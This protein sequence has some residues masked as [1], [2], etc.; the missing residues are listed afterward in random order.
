MSLLMGIDLGTSSV[1]SMIMD[2]SGNVLGFSQKEYDI[3]IPV[4]GYAEQNPAEWWDLVKETSAQAMEQAGTEG[5]TLAGIG[6]SGQMHGLV[7]LD[8]E[9]QVLRPAIIW[10]DQR[11]IPQKSVVES[12]F[13]KEQLGGMIQNPVST[14]FLL[15]SLMWI[16]ENEP[17]IYSK[18]ER[19]M[20]PKDYIRYRLTGELGTDTT[21]ASSTSAYD[22]AALQWSEPLIAAFGLERTMFPVVGSPWEIAGH[23]TLQ[24]ASETGFKAGTPVVYGGADQAMQ[25]IGNGIIEPGDVSCTIGTGGQLLAPMDLPIYDKQLR[26]HTYVHAAPKRW[27]LLGATMS[28]GL[29]L[30][31]LASQVLKNSDYKALDQ[32]ALEIPAGSEGLV[33]LPYLTGE[34]TPHMDPHSRGM[35]FGLQLGHQDAHFVRAVLEGVCYS[36]R[37]GVEIFRS[38]GVGMRRI[39]ISGGGAKSRLWSQILADVLNRDVYRSQAVEQACTGAAMMAGVGA[40]IYGSVEEACKAVVKLHADPVRPNPD[41]HAVYERQYAIYTKLYATN[42][43]L[44]RELDLHGNGVAQ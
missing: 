9:G 40:K 8:K 5:G 7:A 44:L 10:C 29:S 39:I 17:D 41:N 24:A 20:L 3:D 13:T 14:G 11:S 37:D 32:K 33:Y 19:V 4:S 34:R 16:K 30:R 31:W 25:A 43:E 42:R 35:F 21:D 38:L 15:L 23:V 1:K 6:F 22:S 12:T 36:L 18:I 27:Y 28:A 2:S 26:T